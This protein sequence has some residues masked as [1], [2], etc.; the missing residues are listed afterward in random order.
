MPVQVSRPVKRLPEAEFRRS[1]GEN[2]GVLR[3]FKFEL[4]YVSLSMLRFVHDSL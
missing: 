2:N 4:V 3:S 1:E